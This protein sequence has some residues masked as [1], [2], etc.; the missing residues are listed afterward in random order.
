[1]SNIETAKPSTTGTDFS[2][3]LLYFP[4][5]L[6]IPTSAS[7]PGK[8]SLLV[9]QIK[10]FI[11]YILHPICLMC[12]ANSAYSQNTLA[13]PEIKVFSCYHLVSH[14]CHTLAFTATTHNISAGLNHS[15]FLKYSLIKTKLGSAVTVQTTF[16]SKAQLVTLVSC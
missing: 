12:S 15:I 11:I 7:F 8:W 2:I 6:W 13:I 10:Q 1:M 9:N 14:N 16:N 3:T 4:D 5:P